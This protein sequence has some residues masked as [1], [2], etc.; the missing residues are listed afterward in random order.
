MGYVAV[1]K[2]KQGMTLEENVHDVNLRLLMS[3][4]Q[5]IA[6]KHV[7]ILKIWGISEVRIVGGAK[8]TNDRLPEM[9]DENIAVV[10]EAIQSVFKKADLGH[11]TLKQI[12]KVCLI[13]RLKHIGD[14]AQNRIRQPLDGQ[15][16]TLNPAP[17]GGQIGTLDSKLP[18]APTIITELNRVISDPMATSNTV[19]QV[20]NRSPSL[21]ATLLKIVNSA[22]Y[23][24]PSKIDRIS[25]AVT[26]IGTKEVSS[27]AL[28][29]SVMQAFKDI[30]KQIVDMQ[31][32]I[33]HSL[34]CGIISRIVAAFNNNP[35]TEQLFISGLLHDIG[36]LIV[37][38]H[39]PDHAT[40]CFQKAHQED[41]SV[42]Q[43][44]KQFIGMNHSQIASRLIKK[45]KLPLELSDN[46]VYHHL[47][48]KAPLPLN[49]GIVHLADIVTHG[50]GIGS[51]GE[52]SIPRIDYP[53]IEKIIMTSKTD[54]QLIVRQAVHQLG[55]LESIFKADSHETR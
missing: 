46:I 17:I 12:C 8:H 1:D 43:A 20:V 2:L 5:K 24:F 21:A 35:Q 36:K 38:K 30:P 32:F 41:H 22:Y 13:H 48:Q 55:P 18:E 25:R 15:D 50:L 31:A 29:I 14:R 10:K 27:L 54:I 6:E 53:I 3:K 47:P 52:R 40:A 42:Y 23:G 37:Y 4:G 28:G 49:A 7:R 51:S 19:A 45:W 33:S 9:S 11:P 34:A 44:E 26:I 39:F 16:Q